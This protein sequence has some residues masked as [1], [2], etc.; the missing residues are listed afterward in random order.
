MKKS[1][2]KILLSL[3]TLQLMLAP[4]A[5]CASPWTQN[6][7]VGAKMGGKLAYG[8]KNTFFG[9]TAMFIEP[10]QPEYKTEWNGFCVGLAR[11]VVY[12]AGG[13]VQLATFPIPV[14]FP[15]LGPGLH[16]PQPKQNYLQ[17]TGVNKGVP[18]NKPLTAVKAEEEPEVKEAALPPPPAPKEPEAI[19][20]EVKPEEPKPAE[21]Q[22]AA[23]PVKTEEEQPSPVKQKLDQLEEDLNQLTGEEKPA[24]ESAAPEP[25]SEEIAAAKAQLAEKAKAEALPENADELFPDGKPAKKEPSPTGME[26]SL[27]ADDDEMLKEMN[28]AVKKAEDKTKASA[29]APAEISDYTAR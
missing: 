8:L 10:V 6:E 16:I 18:T 7:S 1:V 29:S 15:D 2:K 23:E 26:D 20:Y 17:T 14:D 5:F 4:A 24:S 9:W 21:P 12:T 19:V 27:F 3:L 13:L 22:K 11:S 28:N 25:T